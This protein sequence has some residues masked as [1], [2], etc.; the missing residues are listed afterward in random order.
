MAMGGVHDGG[1]AAIL[2]EMGQKVRFRRIRIQRQHRPA[3]HVHCQTPAVFQMSAYKAPDVLSLFLLVPA[4]GVI[5][6]HR[7]RCAPGGLQLFAKVIPADRAVIPYEGI[8][9]A[10]EGNL[11]ITHA[12]SL[13]HIRL[14]FQNRQ[15]PAQGLLHRFQFRVTAKA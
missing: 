7:L 12:E 8:S 1:I 3:D 15:H 13:L 5:L 2:F 10:A 9:A 6:F 11:Q 14:C 4:H